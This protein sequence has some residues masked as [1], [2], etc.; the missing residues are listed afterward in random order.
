MFWSAENVRVQAL[1]RNG[2]GKEN[3]KFKFEKL[4]TTNILSRLLMRAR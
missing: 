2:K 1:C 4:K 3:Y